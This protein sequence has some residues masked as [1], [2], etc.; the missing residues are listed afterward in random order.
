[1][2]GTNWQGIMPKR[3]RNGLATFVAAGLLTIGGMVSPSAQ[4]PAGSRCVATGTGVCRYVDP[5]GTEPRAGGRSYR[6]LQEAAGS[7]NPGDVVIAGDGVYT[8]GPIILEIRR[9]GT[10]ANPIVFKAENPG[11]AVLDGRDNGAEIGIE[12]SGSYVRVEGFE[13]RGTRHYGIEAYGGSNV[14]VARNHVHDVGH[15]CTST[16]NGIVGIN[17]YVPN[18]LIEQNV[19]HDIGRWAD[20]ENGCSTGNQYWQNHDH[21]IYHGQG[22]NVTIR[23]NVFYNFTRGWAIQR[24]DGAGTVVSNLQIVNNTFAGANPNKDGQIIIA[25]G[26]RRLVIA[27]NI[28]YQ[29]RTAGIWFD[30]GLVTGVVANNLTYGGSVTTGST[31]G[32]TLAGNLTG[33]PL[34]MNAGSFNFQLQSGS[35]AIDRGLSLSIV[36]NDF[37]GTLRPR[38]A[39]FDIGAYE[40]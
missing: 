18:L 22:D 25:T 17:A 32:L 3:N 5:A 26:V 15:Y 31:S 23:N 39:G 14:T 6:T 20:G 9:S 13:V 28:F 35:P 33:N 30:T 1:M 29:P 24:Y 37:L 19:V 21:G 36:L 7:V 38:G 34:F 27:N 2:H 11:G 40:Y 4:A 8:G 10:A 16:S 12:I